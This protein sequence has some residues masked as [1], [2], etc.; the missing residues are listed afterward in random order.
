MLRLGSTPVNTA[1]VARMLYLSWNPDV[2]ECLKIVDNRFGAL[3]LR[4]GVTCDNKKNGI[5]YDEPEGQTH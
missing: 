1:G 4:I 2:Q 5:D 3:S